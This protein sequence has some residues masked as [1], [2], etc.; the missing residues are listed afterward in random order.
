MSEKLPLL[1]RISRYWAVG[2]RRSKRQSS[3]TRQELRVGARIRGFHQ[4]S[5][6]RG[7]SPTR[8]IFSLR[9]IQ[10]ARGFWGSEWPCSLVTKF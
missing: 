6:G 2:F 7:S 9:V 10:M 4:T 1:S 8:F 5:R 3:S